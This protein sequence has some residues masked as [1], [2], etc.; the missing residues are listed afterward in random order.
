M[1]K[2]FTFLIVTC[3]AYTLSGQ[4]P[5][6]HLVSG[7]PDLVGVSGYLSSSQLIDAGSD[8]FFWIGST[9]RKNVTHPLLTEVY[10]DFDNICFIRYDD[11]GAYMSAS[12]IRGTYNIT[13]AFSF[14]GGL[15]VVASSSADVTAGGR[16]VP[17]NNASK[18]E[19]IA[20]YDDNCELLE[21]KG[22]W[23][24]DQYQYPYSEAM[25]DKRDGSVYL[26]GKGNQPFNLNGEGVI[27]EE[28]DDYLYVLKYDRNLELAGVFTA[29]FATDTGE[30]G[31]IPNLAIAPDA[32]GNVMILGSYSQTG[33]SFLKQAP[34]LQITPLACSPSNWTTNFRRYGCRGEPWVATGITMK[35]KHLR[36]WP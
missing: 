10:S 35:S 2:L 18:Q 17:I 30:Y 25:M 1:K 34:F 13:D 16:T 23:D 11:Q 4:N 15:T 7:D 28:L 20:S 9:Y 24:L 22:V 12:Y 8:N 31:Y 14:R 29:G 32:F 6:Q 33:P 3:L 27:G 26:A 21:I 5:G 19:I 36:G